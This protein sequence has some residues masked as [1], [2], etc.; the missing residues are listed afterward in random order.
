MV[1]VNMPGT[2]PGIGPGDLSRVF[3]CRPFPPS[4]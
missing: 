1:K 4:L 2:A 3:P